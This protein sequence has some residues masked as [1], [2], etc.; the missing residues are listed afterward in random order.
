MSKPDLTEFYK[1]GTKRTKDP[2]QIGLARELL[3]DAEREQLDAALAEGR[4]LISASTIVEWLKRRDHKV[5]IPAITSHRHG[6]CT[7]H[8]E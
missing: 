3:K 8:D 6:N 4:G 5:S 2:C 7:C 1:I